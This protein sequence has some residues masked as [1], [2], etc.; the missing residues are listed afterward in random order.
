MSAH[1]PCRASNNTVESGYFGAH[2]S[3]T[4]S[5]RVSFGGS[6]RPQTV[7]GEIFIR[8]LLLFMEKTF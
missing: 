4:R 1:I 3:A 7:V 6:S 8:P 2:N 5:P